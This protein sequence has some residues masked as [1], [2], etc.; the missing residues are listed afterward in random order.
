[1]LDIL[2]EQMK[3]AG[4]VPSTNVVLHDVEVEKKH[5]TVGIHSRK[6][7]LALRLIITSPGTPLWIRK[8]LHVCCDCHTATAIIAGIVGKTLL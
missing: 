3:E 5:V 2:I 4:Y 1:M 8:N 6:L 7:S